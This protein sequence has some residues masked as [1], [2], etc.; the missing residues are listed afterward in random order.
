MATNAVRILFNAVDERLHRAEARFFTLDSALTSKYWRDIL[1]ISFLGAVFLWLSFRL[2]ELLVG[3]VFQIRPVWEHWL[4]PILHGPLGVMFTGLVPLLALFFGITRASHR[5][6][7][8]FA[9]TLDE[10]KVAQDQLRDPSHGTELIRTALAACKHDEPFLSLLEAANPTNRE[11]SEKLDGLSRDTLEKLELLHHLFNMPAKIRSALARFMDLNL[12][13]QEW[14]DLYMTF[15]IELQLDPWR[16]AAQKQRFVFIRDYE[17]FKC[18]YNEDSARTEF[19]D[20]LE[21]DL[22]A[23]LGLVNGTLFS[24]MYKDYRVW[25][26]ESYHKSNLTLLVRVSGKTELRRLFVFDEGLL[27]DEAYFKSLAIGAMWHR[28]NQYPSRFLLRTRMNSQHTLIHSRA[29]FLA[30]CLVNKTIIE[31]D[32]KSEVP[33]G[34]TSRYI[35]RCESDEVLVKKYESQ[36]NRAWQTAQPDGKPEPFLEHCRGLNPAWLQQAEAEYQELVKLTND[37][38]TVVAK[39]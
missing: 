11:L 17:A 33:S 12:R 23:I 10:L 2:E 37:S 21:R 5:E 14:G 36:F 32:Q 9:K 39:A 31:M 30:S 22:E 28:D 34:P 24:V 15:A 6:R 19:E 1:L 26:Q 25:R 35:Y 4:G 29:E 3:V 13:E 38:Q 16:H 7:K 20:R 27:S 18:Y 8:D